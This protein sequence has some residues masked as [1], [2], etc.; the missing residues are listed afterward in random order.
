MGDLRVYVCHQEASHKENK[1]VQKIREEEFEFGL[2]KHIYLNLQSKVDIKK[3]KIIKYL[4]NLN[5][6]QI[7]GFGAPAKATTLIII[8]K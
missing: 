2:A 4:E 7:C 6:G 8:V 3:H 5:Y 1:S